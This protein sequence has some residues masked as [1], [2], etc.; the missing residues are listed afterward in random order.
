MNIIFSVQDN[1][2]GMEEQYSDRI[3]EVFKRL[4]ALENIKEQE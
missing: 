2:I 3:F 4:H 1:G